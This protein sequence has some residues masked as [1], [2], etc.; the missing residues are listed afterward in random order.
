[1]IARRITDWDD[2]YANA[3]N[4]PQGDQ[5]PERW[6]GPAE[7][8]RDSQG[9]ELDVAYG[10]AERHRFDLFRP[11]GTPK[12]LFVFVHGGF[13]VRLDKSYWSHLAG[14]AIQNGWA[15]A[16]PSYPLCP[17]APLADIVAAT[18]MA[19]E[20]A[21]AMIDGPIALAGHSAGGHLVT[22]MIC[23]DTP[24]AATVSN[25][26]ARV[27]SISGLHDLR[28]LLNT[29]LNDA[30]KLDEAEAVRLSPA[31]KRPIDGPDLVTWVGGT[32]RSEFI[33][34][35]RLLAD[36]WLGLGATV[37]EVEEPD[38]HHFDILD[39]MTEPGSDLTRAILG[40]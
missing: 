24:L 40:G 33:R 18:G 3:A 2:A 29:A 16:V 38:R 30:L 26:I 4:I 6:V 14:G 15:V 10:P 11:D 22:S 5:W 31:L 39:S 27:T 8:F 32:E 20:K 13:W 36:I 28:P 17:D 37:S 19:V 34:Q 23:E 21:A 25:R 12:G 7:A 35:S 9:G 1:M